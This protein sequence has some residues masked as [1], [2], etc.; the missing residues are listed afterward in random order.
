M[1]IA[2]GRQQIS[3]KQNKNNYYLDPVMTELINVANQY[4]EGI[5]IRGCAIKTVRAYAYDLLALIRWL[6][7]N[8][9][10]FEKIT[11]KHVFD[12]I[13][14]MREIPTSPATINRRLIVC[15]AF[16]K[17]CNGDTIPKSVKVPY[18]SNHNVRRSKRCQGIAGFWKKP[19]DQLKVKMNHFVID[20]LT[21][22]EVSNFLQ[23]AVRYRDIAIIL[24]MLFCGLRSIEIINLKIENVDFKN[25]C[26]RV[27][28]K[29]GFERF[30]PF[31]E[32][33]AIV[34]N[35]YLRYEKPKDQIN[36]C[37]FV[38]LQGN[39][40]GHSMTTA[41]LRTL[42]RYKRKISGIE[43]A[44]PHLWRHTFATNMACQGVGLPVLQKM[45]GHKNFRMTL[46]YINL[47]MA[48]ITVEYERAIKN[49][50]NRYTSKT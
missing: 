45:M 8:N 5:R 37:F 41:G 22:E 4:L 19:N 3:V 40:V 29:G 28:G 50:E 36:D 10:N 9:I 1:S 24:L 16:F 39:H 47:A 32:K 42:F 31:P 14:F 21:V 34:L 12:W 46:R 17:Y 20:P 43:R 35:R 2:I 7:N 13:V 11:D 26:M 44:N 18:S 23:Y 49:I 30:I 48:D 15:Y 25:K 27:L 38:V 33:L 6:E